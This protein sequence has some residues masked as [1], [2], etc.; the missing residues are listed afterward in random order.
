MILSS[1]SQ[2]QGNIIFGEYSWHSK[3]FQKIPNY[4]HVLTKIVF[5]GHINDIYTY[6]Y[7]YEARLYIVRYMMILIPNSKRSVIPVRTFL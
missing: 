6:K 1:L 5:C 4:S 7:K 2:T 3:N